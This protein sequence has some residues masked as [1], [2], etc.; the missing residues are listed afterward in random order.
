MQRPEHHGKKPVLSQWSWTDTVG[1]WTWPGFTGK[2]VVV[3]VYSAAD[4][5]ELLINGRSIGKSPAGEAQRFT[6]TFDIAYEPGTLEA[7]A[8]RDG[9]GVSRTS[10]TS[11]NGPLVLSAAADREELPADGT[12]VAFIEVTLTD[13]AGTVATGADRLLTAAV[14]GPGELVA[15]GSGRPCTEESY[16]A[17][18]HTT[19]DGRALAVVRATGP[20][21]IT[22]AV[23]SHDGLSAAVTL[24]AALAGDG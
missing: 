14:T 17:D 10:L 15:F 22:L 13:S 21:D 7:I 18:T 1:S 11:A 19:F 24:T 6:A 9:Q 4:E 5:V 20:G 16:Q 3:E 2:P 8:Y 12:D 23:S